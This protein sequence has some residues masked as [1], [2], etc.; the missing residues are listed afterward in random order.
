MVY[1]I[2]FERLLLRVLNFI[3][4]FRTVEGDSPVNVLFKVLYFFLE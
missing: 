1:R 3:W 4:N 2:I